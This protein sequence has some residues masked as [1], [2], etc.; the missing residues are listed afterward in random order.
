M[1]K[2]PPSF[3]RRQAGRFGSRSPS[4]PAPRSKLVAIAEATRSP[5]IAQALD[6]AGRDATHRALAVLLTIAQLTG[7]IGPGQPAEMAMQ[8]LGLLWEGLM[9]GL[10]LGLPRRPSRPRPNDGLPRRQRHFC[11]CIP[12]LPGKDSPRARFPNRKASVVRLP[13]TSGRQPLINA[14]MISLPHP[15]SRTASTGSS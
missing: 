11:S 3:K 1:S 15:S 10:L 6:S 5:E 12:I 8:Y 4:R 2:G 9:V 7:L 14:E 13:L